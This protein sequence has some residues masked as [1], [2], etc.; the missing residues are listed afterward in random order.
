MGERR[1]TPP[2]KTP[3]LSL[4][5]RSTTTTRSTTTR[6]SSWELPS[7]LSMRC[8]LWPVVTTLPSPPSSW[9]LCPPTLARSRRCWT[10]RR[11][12]PVCLHQV[13]RRN[14]Q[15]RQGHREVGGV[16]QDLDV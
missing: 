9:S 3:E 6:P 2:T 15:L 12:R 1:A 13:A 10:P 7:V 8:L 4:L 11:P 14:P 5:P 16:R